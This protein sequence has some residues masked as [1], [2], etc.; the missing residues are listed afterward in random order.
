M[1]NV[2]NGYITTLLAVVTIWFK[3]YSSLH[4]LL[5]YFFRTIR[6]ALISSE[7]FYWI[8]LND[9]VNEGSWRWVNGHR[10]AT[11]DVTLWMQ[12]EPHGIINKDCAGINFRNSQF[13][14]NLAFDATCSRSYK[15]VC[16]KSI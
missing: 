8:G 12:N 16:E 10:A 14:K 2:Q 1:E 7:A 11:N 3:N 15:A 6:H 13:D 4:R 5:F 9:I